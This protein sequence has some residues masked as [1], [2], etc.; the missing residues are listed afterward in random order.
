MS[1][2]IGFRCRRL[3][4]FAAVRAAGPQN[5]DIR[6]DIEDTM[7]MGALAVQADALVRSAAADLAADFPEVPT[8]RVAQAVARARIEI[9]TGYHFLALTDPEPEQFAA[10]VISLARQEL[11]HVTDTGVRT[12]TPINV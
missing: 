9:N 3:G 7:T 5:T 4:N 6:Q 2:R 12:G 8:V 10:D 11:E 1:E